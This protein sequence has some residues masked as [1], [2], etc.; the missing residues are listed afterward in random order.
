[1]DVLEGQYQ[2]ANESKNRMKRDRPISSKYKNTLK[3]KRA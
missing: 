2:T 3:R 1:M